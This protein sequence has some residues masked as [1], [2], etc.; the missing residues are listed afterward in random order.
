MFKIQRKFNPVTKQ[1]TT[2]LKTLFPITFVLYESTRELNYG[3]WR[4][5]NGEQLDLKVYY[6]NIDHCGPC[7]LD[8]YYKKITDKTN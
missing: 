1:I 7:G 8:E 3:R 2:L 5:T 4:P 6:N